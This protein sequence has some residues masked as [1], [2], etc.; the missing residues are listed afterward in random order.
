MATYQITMTVKTETR[1]PRRGERE[2]L[3]DGLLRLLYHESI[4]PLNHPRVSQ[5]TRR[6][7]KVKR[8]A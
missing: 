1:A 4:S 5:A 6:S 2:R 3:R 8:V 7:L